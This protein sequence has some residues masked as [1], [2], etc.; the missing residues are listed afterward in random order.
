MD[1]Q[2]KKITLLMQHEAVKFK[3]KFNITIQYAGYA[4]KRLRQ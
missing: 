2:E 3:R 1:V 4:Y